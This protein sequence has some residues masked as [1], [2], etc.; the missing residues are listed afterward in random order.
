[1]RLSVKCN[2]QLSS[3]QLLEKVNKFAQGRTKGFKKLEIGDTIYLEKHSIESL[4]QHYLKYFNEN[5]VEYGDGFAT[6]WDSD[7]TA[8]ILYKN[9]QIRTLNPQWDDG[10]KKVKLDG[11]DSIIVDGGWGTAFAGPSV[12]F[13]DETVYEDIP[14]IRADFA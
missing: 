4:I 13:K 14:D 10:T 8:T 12:I 6:D 3:Q 11:I 1:M 9:G 2:Q 7:D 5:V